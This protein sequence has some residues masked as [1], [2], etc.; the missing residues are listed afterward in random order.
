MKLRG[1][2]KDF[3]EDEAMGIRA[4]LIL[5]LDVYEAC[6]M[7]DQAE[8][9]VA[10]LE[11]KNSRLERRDLEEPDGP[12]SCRWSSLRSWWQG[13]GCKTKY[14]EEGSSLYQNIT[15]NA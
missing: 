13:D 5:G 10:I 1:P 6:G 15:I 8:G 7:A 12:S 3:I 11:M 2:E 14:P 4:P 9:L